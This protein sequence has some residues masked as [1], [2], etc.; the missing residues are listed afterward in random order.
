VAKYLRTT[1]NKNII[2]KEIKRRI[3]SGN[4][5]YHAGKNVLSYW[6][7]SKNLKIKTYLSFK[8]AVN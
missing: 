4:A 3:N 1:T 7:L 6:L 5:C 2:H 8:Y